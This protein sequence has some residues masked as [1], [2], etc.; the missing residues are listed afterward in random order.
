MAEME[1]SRVA[2]CPPLLSLYENEGEEFLHSI[3]TADDTWVHHYEPETK[4][5]SMEYCRK[6]SLAEKSKSRFG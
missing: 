4:R 3:I 2:I 6:V 1:A 5:Q